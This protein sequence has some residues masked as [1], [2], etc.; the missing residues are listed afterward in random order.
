[1]GRRLGEDEK[2]WGGWERR[3][4]KVLERRSMR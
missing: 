2:S 1:M 4:G 3:S